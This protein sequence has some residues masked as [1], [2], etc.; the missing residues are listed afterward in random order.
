MVGSLPNEQ[1]NC[2]LNSGAWIS[3]CLAEWEQRCVGAVAFL[4][5]EDGR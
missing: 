3:S 5:L 2:K 1:L 4:F